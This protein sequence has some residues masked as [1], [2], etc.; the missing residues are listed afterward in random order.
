[1]I[2][3]AHRLSTLKGMDRII[4]LEKGSIIEDGSFKKLLKHR[5]SFYKTYA[6]QNR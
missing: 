1:M 4:Y 6:A 2:V 3:I 5:K